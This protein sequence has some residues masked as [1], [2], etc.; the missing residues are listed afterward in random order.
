MGHSKKESI[1]FVAVFRTTKSGKESQSGA[2]SRAYDDERGGCEESCCDCE[3]FA[4]FGCIRLGNDKEV[5]EFR[6]I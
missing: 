1:L 6:L 4:S 5:D 2:S 3:L